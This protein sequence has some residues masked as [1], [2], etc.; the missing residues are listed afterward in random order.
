MLIQTSRAFAKAVQAVAAHWDM[1]AWGATEISWTS[2]YNPVIRLKRKGRHMKVHSFR[3]FVAPE[4]MV[5]AIFEYCDRC[6]PTATLP[7][8]ELFDATYSGKLVFG[9]GRM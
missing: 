3:Q 2:F 1:P 9:G 8:Q 6:S 5:T 7:I 4:R